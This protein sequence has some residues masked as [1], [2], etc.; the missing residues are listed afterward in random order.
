MS[1][2]SGTRV[3]PYEILGE[4]GAGGMGVVYRARD[5]RLGRTVAIK[6]LPPESLEKPERVA[7][8]EQEAKAA[9]ARNHPNILTIYDI[10]QSGETRYIAM[11]FV[12][13]ETVRQ[14]IRRGPVPIKRALDITAQAARSEEHTSEL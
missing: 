5:S 9:S 1:L 3:G 2:P 6:V 11:E 12:E 13:G 4:V 7:R 14:L 8:F 10:G